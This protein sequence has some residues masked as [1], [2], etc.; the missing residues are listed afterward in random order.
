MHHQYIEKKKKLICKS[1]FTCWLAKA[2]NK[3]AVLVA[4]TID[5]SCCCN[6]GK[7]CLL[8]SALERPKLLKIRAVIW[9]CLQQ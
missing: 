9:Q 8:Y 7:V 2:K 6:Y 5:Q 4:K 1:T 3:T